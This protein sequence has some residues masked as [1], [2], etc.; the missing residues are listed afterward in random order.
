[1]LVVACDELRERIEAGEEEMTCERVCR[2]L[3]K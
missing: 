1:M 2:A 3:R